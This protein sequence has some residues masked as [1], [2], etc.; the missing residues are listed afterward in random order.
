MHDCLTGMEKVLAPGSVSVVV[1]SPPYNLGVKY[2]T[3][4]DTIP[5]DEYLEW[6]ASWAS[7]V[8]SVL[9]TDGSVFL[10]IG[11]RPI[12]PWV[13]FEVIHRLRDHFVLQN[14][15]HWIKSIFVENTS[16]GRRMQ[17]NVGH[18]KPV[19]SPRFLNDSHEYVFHL[20]VH[21]K[22]HLDRLA[23]GVPY[24]D[25][26]NITR[27]GKARSGVRCRGNC[28]YVPYETIGRRDRDRPHPASF[29][30]QLAEMCIRLHGLSKTE[31]VMDPFM[32][33]GNTAMACRDLG[34]DFVGF[35]IDQE[36]FEETSRRI[37]AGEAQPSLFGKAPQS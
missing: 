29:P 32:G 2:R 31:M 6:L 5:R 20:T 36:Y 8:R 37:Q 12:D 16:Y 15:I 7:V 18:Y 19:N 11:S 1:T 14:V 23:I 21:G 35:E 27:W 3:Y 13:P 34:L 30:P 9:H 17:M 25:S 26:S 33:I 22:V 24:K 10:N 4:D 28:W